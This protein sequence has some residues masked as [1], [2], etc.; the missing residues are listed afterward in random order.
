MILFEDGV[1]LRPRDLSAKIE[2]I[3]Q[4]HFDSSKKQVLFGLG[5]DDEVRVHEES[6]I[7][8]HLHGGAAQ[9]EVHG[10]SLD[11]YL[12]GDAG[13]DYIYGK[14]GNDHLFGGPGSDLMTGYTGRN[15]FYKD[16]ADSIRPGSNDQV[17]LD[18]TASN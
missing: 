8:G 11:D 7:A 16:S 18:P 14:G 10:G 4:G 2:D 9:D 3:S 5:G 1:G 17:V 13:N 12:Y 15:T 6:N